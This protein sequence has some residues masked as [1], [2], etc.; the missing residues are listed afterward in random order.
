MPEP[1]PKPQPHVLI[2]G[3]AGFIGSNLAADLLLKTDARITIFDNLSRSG[4]QLNLTWL[5]EQAGNGRLRFM[6]GDVRNAQ[7]IAAAV[8]SADEV[9]HLA[10]RCPGMAETRVDGNV[11]VTGTLNVLDAARRSPR[12]PM[13]LF[14][15]I[16]D[17]YGPL[18]GLQVEPQGDRYVPVDPEFHGIPETVPPDPAVLPDCSMAQAD[19]FMADFARLYGVRSVV[20]RVD[21]V[22]GPRQFVSGTQGWVSAFVY[23]VLSGSPLQVPENGLQV[24]DVLHVSDLVEAMLSARAYL[25]VTAGKVYNVGGGA[26]HAISFNEMIELIE[27]VSYRKARVEHVLTA[28]PVRPLYF[29]NSTAFLRDTNWRVRRTLE[30]TVR[31]IITFWQVNRCMLGTGDL[32]GTRPV[33][34]RFARAA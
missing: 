24:R 25:G 15:S 10:G 28:A 1:A 21:T 29:A 14:A 26:S 33:P 16:T 32:P 7:S 4:S 5:K 30:R 6:R 34:L 22:A 23:S 31:D 17:V 11:N 18:H 12:R 27:R 3:G 9:Y 8:S 2:T 19:R 13:V 20:L